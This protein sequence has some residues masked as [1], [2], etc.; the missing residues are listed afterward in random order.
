[1]KNNC[2]GFLFI[3]FILQCILPYGAASITKNAVT[4]KKSAPASSITHG[5]S[6]SYRVC[7]RKGCRSKFDLSETIPMIARRMCCAVKGNDG[8]V[9][10]KFV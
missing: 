2:I 4:N 7:D 8:K 1:M 5:F 3:A 6:A 9:S 10:D